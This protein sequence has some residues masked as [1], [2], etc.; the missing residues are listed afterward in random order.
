MI[1]EK[2]VN[3]YYSPLPEKKKNLSVISPT[4]P[5]GYQV[6]SQNSLYKSKTH[7]EFQNSRSPPSEGSFYFHG[8]RWMKVVYLGFFF[9][10]LVPTCPVKVFSARARPPP[11]PPAMTAGP[12]FQTAAP[13]TWF[14]SPRPEPRCNC[15]PARSASLPGGRL[16]GPALG[17]GPP[18]WR[19]W[20]PGAARPSPSRLL[21]PSLPCGLCSFTPG[22]HPACPCHGRTAFSLL[23][24]FFGFLLPSLASFYRSLHRLHVEIPGPEKQSGA[25]SESGETN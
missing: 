5:P 19:T 12:C 22:L 2:P 11:P 8:P 17:P 18:K 3:P 23:L 20:E 10:F 16:A 14:L 24:H 1:W 25:L 21:P 4:I 9:F 6:K 15:D 13:A 7:T